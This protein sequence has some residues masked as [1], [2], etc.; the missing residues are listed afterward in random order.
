MQYLEH[1]WAKKLS[2]DYLKIKLQW[3]SAA[4]RQPPRL[5]LLPLSDSRGSPHHLQHL[6]ALEDLRADPDPGH[7]LLRADDPTLPVMLVF[8]QN[9]KFLSIFSTLPSIT[10]LESMALIFEHITQICV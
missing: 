9:L 5:S 4:D 6:P 1:V 2:A 7:S 10:T 3:A 8:I